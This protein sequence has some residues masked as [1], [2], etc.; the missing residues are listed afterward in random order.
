MDPARPIHA[1]RRIPRGSR[2]LRFFVWSVV[3]Q[4]AATLWR[5][6]LSLLYQFQRN[7]DKVAATGWR[8]V[9]GETVRHKLGAPFSCV[10]R[11]FFFLRDK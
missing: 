8:W 11:L 2:G 5:S 10:K 7:D 9:G 3:R 1:C 6:F 4:I